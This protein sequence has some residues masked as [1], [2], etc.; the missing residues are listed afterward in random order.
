MSQ[1]PTTGILLKAIE[2][3][4]YTSSYNSF[5]THIAISLSPKER[6]ELSMLKE[7]HEVKLQQARREA[8][9]RLTPEVREALITLRKYYQFYDVSVNDSDS[10]KIEKHPRLVELESREHNFFSMMQNAAYNG[11]IM[12]TDLP[13]PRF[14]YRLTTEEL[15]E[16][17]SS[18]LMEEILKQQ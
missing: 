7:E 12:R 10:I 2:N 3:D 8:F 18:S 6:D 17:H 13:V 9:K 5:W 16:A 11:Y 14:I 1:N 15:L 4:L